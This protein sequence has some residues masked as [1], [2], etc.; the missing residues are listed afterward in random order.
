MKKLLILVF[1]L[2]PVVTYGASFADV[3]FAELVSQP[4]N[5]SS[6]VELVNRTGSDINI[7]DWKIKHIFFDSF[8]NLVTSTTTFDDLIIP[9]KGLVSL[10]LALGTTSGQAILYDQLGKL[11]HGISY[12]SINDRDTD[13]IGIPPT[14]GQSIITSGNDGGPW[15]VSDI[16]SRNWF[17][18]W[19]TKQEILDT[20]PAGVE[21]N[22]SGAGGEVAG[23]VTDWVNASGLTFS[24]AGLGQVSWPMS[25]N[26]TGQVARAT[27]S[28]LNG[29]FDFGFGYAKIKSTL[30]A[31][32]VASSMRVTLFGLPRASYSINDISV[33]DDNGNLLATS[34]SAYPVISDF[35][36]T[37]DA[38]SA[39][40]TLDFMTSLPAT[41]LVPTSTLPIA[42]T[43]PPDSTTTPPTSTST[44]PLPPDSSSTP[45]VASSTLP[46]DPP[47]STTP[48]VLPPDSTTTLPTHNYS[49]GGGGALL[50]PRLNLGQPDGRVLG[51]S[52]FRFNRIMRFGMTGRDVREL[53][54]ILQREG[55]YHL[56]LAGSFGPATRLALIAWQKKYHLSA[57][58]LAGRSTLRALNNSTD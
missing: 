20:L 51:A 28:N 39:S 25:L 29:V 5:G 47:A 8:G 44:P 41:F 22:L 32:L 6:W 58:G 37:F 55:F 45:P 40:G 53:Q 1:L 14:I 30:G 21:N 50:W 10:D 16:V 27:L 24:R 19:P 42:T 17:N 33:F 56:G 43:T 2:L 12:G 48:P 15:S 38:G 31:P 13:N 34:S 18:Q 49:G 54:V 35:S 23:F 7:E 4:V 26:L 9:T 3:L 46:I 36:Y 57:T 52:A 11:I